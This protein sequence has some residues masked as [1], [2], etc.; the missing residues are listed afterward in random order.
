MSKRLRLATATINYNEHKNFK[1][2]WSF[3]LIKTVT[4]CIYSICEPSVSQDTGPTLATMPKRKRIFLTFFLMLS[5]Q[6]SSPSQKK[7]TGHLQAA[8][9]QRR[10]SQI[11]HVKA[12]ANEQSDAHNLQYR[13]Y[14]SAFG[15]KKRKKAPFPPLFQSVLQ[16]AC[17]KK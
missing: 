14:L 11:S 6:Q 2:G 1:T 8:C 13:S 17:F 16:I 12:T 3:S 9:W 7:G 4:Y 10:L 15:R 5:N